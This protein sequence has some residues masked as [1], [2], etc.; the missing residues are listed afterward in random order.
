MIRCK[1]S[2]GAF[3]AFVVST[4]LIVAAA[5]FIGCSDSIDKVSVTGEGAKAAVTIDAVLCVGCAA[6]PCFESCPQ[7]AI[8]FRVINDKYIYIIDPARCT[9]CGIC[10]AKCPYNAIVWTR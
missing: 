1:T 7:R 5:L 2:Y 9:D 4:C 3:T 10:I 6:Q 8:E